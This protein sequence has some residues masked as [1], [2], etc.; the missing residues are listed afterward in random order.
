MKRLLEIHPDGMQEWLHWDQSEKKLAIEYRHDAQ[1]TVDHNKAIDS[2]SGGWSKSREWKH[3]ASVPV[4]VQ[5]EM[6]NRYGVDPFKR[7]HEDL[8]KRA[9]N[10][11][12]YRYLR[13]GGMV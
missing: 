5:L 11:P 2:D 9:L 7:G 3:V 8:L 6:I 4:T 1:A 12:D 13:I 10:D